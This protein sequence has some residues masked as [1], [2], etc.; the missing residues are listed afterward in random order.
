MLR[1]STACLVAGLAACSS[2][3]PDPSA[4]GSE[5]AEIIGGV[6]D[7]GHA[8]VVGV[9]GQN[10]TSCTGTLISRRTVLTAGHCIGGM[11]HVHF[12]PVGTNKVAIS[13]QKR[14][15]DY[16]NSAANDLG[17]L[18][19]AADAP[20]QPAPLLRETLD[21]SPTFIGPKFT[22]V[23]YGYDENNGYG[24]KR[25]ATFPIKKIGPAQNLP[26]FVGQIDASEF[27][28]ALPN[29]NTCN[30][31]SGGPAFAIR[32]GVERHAG[33]T[34]WGDQACEEDGVQA[35][36]DNPAIAEFIQPNI[37]A[38]EGAD[39]ACRSNG[40]CDESCNDVNGDGQVWDPDCQENHCGA[41]GLCALACVAPVDPDC[42]G[43]NHCVVDGVCDPSCANGDEADCDGLASLPDAGVPDASIPDASPPD[44]ALPDAGTPDADVIV[45]GVDA[46]PSFPIDA[47]DDNSD[48][49]GD[50]SDGDDSGMSGGCGCRTGGTPGGSWLGGLLLVGLA[51]A[52]L[53]RRRQ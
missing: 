48:N 47:G 15:P 28:Y 4:L 1:I 51:F 38:F 33:A 5:S 44:A 24:K 40:V 20:T 52:G 31:D 3:S 17:I 53:R 27:Y 16:Q 30:G 34:S 10:S 11:S 13:Q 6:P 23:G 49:S 36:T 21:E 42:T 12:G 37:D 14:H 46:S 25:V 26:T 35:R 9:G 8:Y 18:K 32:G 19:L 43:V 41:D 45:V 39:N 2:S 22:F 29:L 50:G 7:P